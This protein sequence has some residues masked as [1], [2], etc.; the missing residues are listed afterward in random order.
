MSS[1]ASTLARLLAAPQRFTFDAAVR[2]LQYASRQADPAEA[3]FYLSVPGLNY[4]GG[5]FTRV[6]PADAGAIRATTP[7]MGLTGATG[8]LPRYY[9]EV[10]G[11][12]LR[13]RSRAMH[14][15]LDL[16]ST[17][18]VGHFARAGAKYRLTRAVENGR[19]AAR[20]GE[21]SVEPPVDP[22]AM[23]LQ[24]FTGFGTPGLRGRVLV[25][26]EPILHYAGAFA[27]R[28]R[29]A[30][31]L[32]AFVSDWLGRRVEVV[33]FAGQWLPLD[34]PERTRM[35]QGRRPGRFNR[36][37]VD[38]AIGVR[39]WD[40]QARIILRIGPLAQ[41]EFIALLPDRPALHRLVALVRAYLG[42]EIGFAVNL[43]LA[44]DAVP[45][46][47]LG[48][49]TPSARLASA[50]AA[51]PLDTAAPS[52]RLGWTTWLPAPGLGRHSDPRDAVFEAEIVE[53]AELVA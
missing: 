52:A 32:A 13:D 14:D 49:S 30:D 8:V 43:V 5:D 34:P 2:A 28:P 37:G 46:L 3:A 11:Q 22:V 23:M 42:L 1:P 35:P 48:G 15:F 41:A 21:P 24:A 40:L 44:R 18:M 7:V 36:L 29:S 51:A 19:L 16:L 20:A 27:T 17:R 50:A 6:Q 39:A 12:T 33:Q 9:S 47:L 38:A 4:G 53:Q 26:M 10:L 31:R 45:A 25:G